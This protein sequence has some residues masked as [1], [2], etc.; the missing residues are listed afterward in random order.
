M[1]LVV[2]LVAGALVFTGMVT[3]FQ[4][5]RACLAPPP[6]GIVGVILGSP[7][8]PMLVIIG[9]RGSWTMIERRFGGRAC[10]VAR[11]DA[12]G[13]AASLIEPSS[14]EQL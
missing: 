9:D 10:V 4:D 7:D 8:R 14:G 12:V 11:G 5:A 13:I 6:D 2:V 1:R 3:V